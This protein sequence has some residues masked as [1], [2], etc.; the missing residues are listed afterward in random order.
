MPEIGET[1]PRDDW[2][3]EVEIAFQQWVDWNM[4]FEDDGT[5]EREWYSGRDYCNSAQYQGTLRA[6]TP[7]DPIFDYEI[8]LWELNLNDELHNIGLCF[9][10]KKDSAESDRMLVILTGV[11]A[12]TYWSTPQLPDDMTAPYNQENIDRTRAYLAELDRKQGR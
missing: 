9:Y 6:G 10:V 8:Q 4:S 11:E 2:P 1:V 7:P 12:D 5:V 3:K